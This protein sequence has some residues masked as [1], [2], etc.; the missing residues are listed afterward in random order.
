MILK[1]FLGFSIFIGFIA[2]TLEAEE[3]HRKADKDRERIR[4][5]LNRIDHYGKY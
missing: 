4:K 5:M 2:A 3:R 1:I